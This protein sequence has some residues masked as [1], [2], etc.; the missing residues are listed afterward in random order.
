MGKIERVTDSAAALF[1]I[2][3][4]YGSRFPVFLRGVITSLSEPVDLSR[5]NGECVVPFIVKNIE[6]TIKDGTELD[7]IVLAERGIRVASYSGDKVAVHRVR[8]YSDRSYL[9]F[10]VDR[11][12]TP[13]SPKRVSL[14]RTAV[15]T[16][17]PRFLKFGTG[18]DAC[19]PADANQRANAIL[20]VYV[21]KYSKLPVSPIFT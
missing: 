13:P 2:D 21:L 19:L 3:R 16:Y 20:K 7:E 15:L 4:E 1:R 11:A 14:L 6:G 8:Q 10:A 5:Q 12:S 17:D 9:K 18:Y